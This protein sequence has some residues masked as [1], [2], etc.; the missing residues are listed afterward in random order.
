MRK[1]L[2]FLNCFCSNGERLGQ[3]LCADIDIF[4]DAC[5]IKPG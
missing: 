3:R 1:L 4:C 5:R 2:T